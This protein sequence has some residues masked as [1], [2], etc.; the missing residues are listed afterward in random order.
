MG[1]LNSMSR[2]SRLLV[3]LSL[4]LLAGGV[5]LAIF[6]LGQAIM[7]DSPAATP[8]P[9]EAALRPL[10]MEVEIIPSFTP[11]FTVPP[12]ATLIPTQTA[13]PTL[14]PTNTVTLTPTQTLLPTVTPPPTLIIAAP[15]ASPTPA[16]PP[17]PA[18]WV[19]HTVQVGETLFAFQL[20]TNNT[21]TVDQIIAVNCLGGRLIYEGQ[22][23]WLPPDAAENAPSSDASPIPLPTDPAAPLPP[24]GLTRSPQCPCQITLQEGWRLEQIAEVI[25]SL[26]LGFRG[27]DFLAVAG[28]GSALAGREFMA[29]APSGASLEGYML[30]NTYTVTNDMDAAAFVNMVLDAFGAATSGLWADAA[31]RGLT[32]YQTVT[33]ASIVNRESRSPD[34]Q[35][36]IS[37]VFHN[38]LA[39]G[40]NLGATV[41]TQYAL[42]RSGNW[43]PNVAGQVSTLDSP[44]NTN[45]Y[46][47]LPPSPICSPSLD[48]LR[49]A[50]YPAQTNYLYFTGS[51][52]GSGNVYAETYEQHL[53]N[54]R[55]Q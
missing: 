23:L 12:S 44:Y 54:V 37:S 25:D 43:W 2:G 10:V 42:G 36:L 18:D 32:P 48:A 41:T 11:S 22:K 50:V 24:S 35:V 29:G 38:R 40:R 20:G 52:S 4:M 8:V 13:S 17:P 46:T 49:A 28:R 45:T 7:E 55:C 30:P 16:C 6:W 27:A 39:S 51:C 9:T 31:A 47:G 1:R 19:S 26:P 3:G 14:T 5:T 33:L 34:Q 15:N 53:A 21:V